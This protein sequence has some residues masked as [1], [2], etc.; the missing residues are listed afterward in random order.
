MCN[1]LAAFQDNTGCFMTDNAVAVEDELAD[2]TGFPEVNV[3]PADSGGFDMKEN[4]SLARD[5]HRGLDELDLVVG[6]DLERGI[7]E[8]RHGGGVCEGE[9]LLRVEKKKKCHENIYRR[10]QRERETGA[11]GVAPSVVAGSE[12]ALASEFPHSDSSASGYPIR[13]S[14]LHR[15]L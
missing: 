8:E 15:Q 7:G 12:C 4:L 11:P 10:A 14:C 2:A 9:K 6:G 1:A 3:R 5:V 13:Q